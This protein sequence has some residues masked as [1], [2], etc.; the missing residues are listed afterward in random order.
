MTKHYDGDVGI[1]D[2]TGAFSLSG[3]VKMI[4]KLLSLCNLQRIAE[5][6]NKQQTA[7]DKFVGDQ[8]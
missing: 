3:K 5:A 2:S 6:V 7:N 8:S 1:F 4:A